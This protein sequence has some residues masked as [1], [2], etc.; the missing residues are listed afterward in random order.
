MSK[1]HAVLYRVARGSALR[2]TVMKPIL[3]SARGA[4][5]AAVRSPPSRHGAPSPLGGSGDSGGAVA[6]TKALAK[7][8]Y[9]S[10]PLGAWFRLRLS[11]LGRDNRCE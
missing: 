5:A 1:G 8:L 10:L 2:G 11:R 3:V 4:G 7:P 6:D 9:R